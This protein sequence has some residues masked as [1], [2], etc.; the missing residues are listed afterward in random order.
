M[1]RFL[2]I[3][4]GRLLRS[5]VLLVL[6]LA[7]ARADEPETRIDFNRDIRPILS[8]T[9]YQCHG[10]DQ[11]KRKAELRLDTEAGALADLGGRSALVP[12]NLDQSELYQRIIA[13]DPEERM[14]PPKSGK[15]LTARQIDLIRRWIEQGGKWQKHWSFIPPVRP[16]PPEVKNDQWVRNPVDAFIAARLER[17][18]LSPSPE[19]DRITLL[20]RVSFDLTGLPPTPAEVEAF[21]DDQSA[22]AYEAAVDRLLA[23]PRFGERMAVRWLDG[24]RYADTNGYQ[25]DGE[26]FMWRWRD[27]VIDAYNRNLPFDKFTIEQLAGDMLPHATLDQQ[28]ASGFNRNHRGNAEGGIV[29]EEYAVEYVVDRVETTF[30]VWMGLT[31]GCGR[32]HDHTFDPLTQRDFY[33]SFAYF[34]NVPEFGRAVKYGNSPPMIKAPTAAQ[35]EILRE[36]DERLH[37]AETELARNEPSIAA[38][39]HDWEKTLDPRSVADWSVREGLRVHFSLDATPQPSEPR[40]TPVANFEGGSAHFAPGRI[41]QAAEFDGMRFIDAGDLANIGFYDKFTL[42][43]WIYPRGSQGGTILSRMTDVA[44]GDGYAL[45][46]AEGRLQLNLVKRWLDDSVRVETERRLAPD[47]WHHVLVTC[48]GSRQA[49][50][51]T[52]HVDGHAEPMRVLLDLLN[53]PFAAKEPLRI[54]GGNGPEGRFHGLI[55]EVRIYDRV[56]TDAEVQIAA[57]PEPVAELVNDPRNRPGSPEWKKVRQCFLERGAPDD[58]RKAFANLNQLHRERERL[59]DSFPTT[60]VMREM[61]EPRETFVLIR[62]EYTRPGEKV[63]AAIPGCL[64]PLPEGA[65]NNRL[66]F[67]RWLVS[68]GHPLTARVAVNRLWQMLFGIGL[69]KTVDDFGAQG[70]WPSHPELL[71]WLAMEFAAPSLG[72]RNSE[73]PQYARAWD[74]KRVLRLLVTSAT[75]R[76]SSR[77]TPEMQHRDPENRLLARG[78]RLRLSAE[79]VRDQALYAA[80]LLV[81]KPGGPSVKPYQ[82]DGL[83][84]ELADTDYVQDTGESLYRRSMYTFWKRTVAPPTMVTFDEAGRE[85]CIVRETRTNTPLQALTLMNDVTFVEASRALAERIM[86]DAGPDPDDRLARAFR[87]ALSRPPKPAELKILRAGWNFQ[88][89]RFAGDPAGAEKLLSLG[90]LPRDEQLDI[91]ELAAYTTLA[92]VILNLDE[93]ITKE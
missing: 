10:P 87:L 35:Q 73:R 83:W 49:S 8:D 90:E 68:P 27:W 22:N 44:Q 43:A 2:T 53:Q 39:Q 79:M 40:E 77:M 61:S 54:G 36:F 34:N 3:W 23:S 46:L 63:T 9:C 21:L 60:M 82:P 7:L 15:A 69:V 86:Q 65:S 31:M 14:P 19:A 88:R 66:G 62:G 89:D 25:S 48:D 80:G 59:M 76:Q 78:P 72:Q 33:Q 28:I 55:D 51:I 12:S 26:R 92:G 29:P 41:G 50:G 91:V 18:G 11:A 17:D 37:A 4:P 67:A 47:T 42:S 38:A 93:T 30:T 70:E 5:G 85:T 32:C 1:Q 24:A 81:E 52:F 64:P 71:D 6:L 16:V 74:V 84:K 20:R 13:N 58:M 56:L 75:Y 45:V 57:I